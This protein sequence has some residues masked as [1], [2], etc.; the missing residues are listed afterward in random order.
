VRP[1]A[2]VVYRMR[3]VGLAAFKLS[4]L[5]NTAVVA[6][7]SWNAQVAWTPVSFSQSFRRKGTIMKSR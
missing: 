4:Y 5:L 7:C 1:H 2:G 6:M 3:I